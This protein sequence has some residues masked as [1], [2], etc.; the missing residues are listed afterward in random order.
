MKFSTV[1]LTVCI[2][3]CAPSFSSLALGQINFE[4]LSKQLTEDNKADIEKDMA[5]NIHRVS[6]EQRSILSDQAKAIVKE[7]IDTFVS[8]PVS[9][10]SD[11]HVQTVAN[12]D[13]SECD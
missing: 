4:E 5:E 1:L 11:K 12:A 3:L 7:Q 2:G 8:A 6:I 10:T 13:E 9:D